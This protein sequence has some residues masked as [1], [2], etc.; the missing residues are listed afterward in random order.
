MQPA[1][2]RPKKYA[3]VDIECCNMCGNPAARNK[4]MGIRLNRS[5]GFHPKSKTGIAV[6]VIKCAN[7]SLIYADPM[8]IPDDIQ[9]HYGL[10]PEEYWNTINFDWN[11]DYFSNE[12]NKVQQLMSFRAGMK[13]LDIGSGLGRT[14]I[15]LEKAGFETFGIE[16]SL[17]FYH[18]AIEKMKIDPARLQ[19]GSL[20]NS[21]YEPDCFDLISFGAV[22]EHLYDP[23]KSIELALGWLKPGGIIH[24]EVP[25]SNHFPTRLINLFYKL[26]GTNYVSNLSPMHTPFHLYEFSLKSFELNSVRLNYSI[27]DSKIEVCEILNFP[28]FTHPLLKKWMSLTNSGL[29]LVVYLKK[30]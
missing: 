9:D 13:A 19:L 2:T 3:F 21:V 26:K 16:P 29:Q 22:L 8:P 10:P 20:E 17:P 12:I 14:M 4:T 30:L 7:C 1:I 28:R 25:S 11:E 15:S 5:Q 18:S 24:I 23:S 6:S 27:V